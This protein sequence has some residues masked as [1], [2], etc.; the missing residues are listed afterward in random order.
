MKSSLKFI[1]RTP[2]QIVVETQARSIRVLTETGHVGLR[3]K[4]EAVILTVEPG[5]V[6]VQRE[7]SMLFVGTS[8]GLL[9]CDGVVAT[10][11]TPLAVAAK[12]QESVMREL[13]MQLRQPKAEL[14]VRTTINNIQSS[15]LTEITDDRRR[16]SNHPG[17]GP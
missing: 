6:L 16:R 7:D 4:M 12:N 15:I 14:E 1:V 2:R 17:V 3:P 10:L 13:Q 5:L 8:G 11:L 9:K